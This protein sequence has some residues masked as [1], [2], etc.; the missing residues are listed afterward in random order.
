MLADSLPNDFAYGGFTFRTRFMRSPGG[1]HGDLS[2]LARVFCVTRIGKLV[3]E[4]EDI[5]E[6][7]SKA[8][9][10][11]EDQSKYICCR[12]RRAEI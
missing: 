4:E 5:H 9:Y 1:F 10:I 12:E 2:K 8:D 3:V 11:Y 7:A 6:V